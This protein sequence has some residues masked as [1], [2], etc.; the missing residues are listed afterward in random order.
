MEEQYKRASC[1]GKEHVSWKEILLF[2]FIKRLVRDYW[3]A[4]RMEKNRTIA[5][6]KYVRRLIEWNRLV[7][8]LE[9]RTRNI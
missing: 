9:K 1:D 5:Q 2:F 3:R 8:K 4:H 6:A 7:E